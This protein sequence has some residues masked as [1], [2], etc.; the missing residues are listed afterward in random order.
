MITL[1]NETNPL[2]EKNV[3]DFLKN[4]TKEMLPILSIMTGEKVELRKLTKH[5]IKN[6]KQL[7][8]YL[9]DYSNRTIAF[10]NNQNLSPEEKQKQGFELADEFNRVFLGIQSV[11]DLEQKIEYFNPE[12]SYKKRIPDQD[13]RNKLRYSIHEILFE[14]DRQNKMEDFNKFIQSMGI[15]NVLANSQSANRLLKKLPYLLKER[16]RITFEIAQRY[17]EGYKEVASFM[18]PLITILYG[19]L[20]II[21]G[22]YRPYTD[23]K[24][25]RIGI[26]GFASILKKEDHFSN[27]IEPYDTRIRN[28]IIHSTY[29][30]DPISKKIEFL[31]RD[32]KITKTFLEFIEYVKEIT[33]RGII[34]CHLEGEVNYLTYKHYL[35]IRKNTSDTPREY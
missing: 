25:D 35:Q 15:D 24:T 13:Y 10:Q 2:T 27:L 32:K 19:L 4:F 17:V 18:E 8:E 21:Q 33:R 6:T 11:S 29:H 9:Q 16:K 28:A 31:D 7:F 3:K 34:I 30:L 26:G 23:L 14:I 12:L 5:N 20:L 22:K 1:M